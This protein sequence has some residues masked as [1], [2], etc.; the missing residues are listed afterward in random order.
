MT[1]YEP[2]IKPYK[3]AIVVAFTVCML[4][5]T[6]L[7]ALGDEHFKDWMVAIGVNSTHAPSSHQFDQGKKATMGITCAHGDLII[8]VNWHSSL[9]WTNLP[10]SMT[11][12]FDEMLVE[13]SDWA[14]NS[15][16]DASY[17]QGNIRKLIEQLRKT[18]ELNIHYG[19]GFHGQEI[20]AAFKLAGLDKAVEV[21]ESFCSL[22]N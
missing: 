13:S 15:E 20:S 8:Y 12:W 6:G 4:A 11:L 21:V 19:K 9:D 17:Y 16:N 14:H 5:A 18:Q 2:H 3:R 7:P 10:S 22:L 1:L